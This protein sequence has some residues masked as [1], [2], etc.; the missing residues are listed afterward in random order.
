MRV[1][2]A[3]FLLVSICLPIWIL[4]SADV[5]SHSD[6][7]TMLDN[8]I[9]NVK[10]MLGNKAALRNNDLLHADLWRRLGLMLQTKDVRQHVGGGA[11]QPEALA[12]F[13]NALKFNDDL[14][15]E[16][17]FQVY[18]HRGML[19]KMM[20]RGDEAIRSHDMAYSLSSNP[21]EK[22]D[23]MSQKGA[24]QVMLGRVSEAINSYKRVLSIYPQHLST[25]LPLV[26]AHLELGNFTSSD[27]SVLLK[28]IEIAVGIQKGHSFGRDQMKHDH[29]SS[30]GQ[31][32]EE[33]SVYF[34]LFEVK[35]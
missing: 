24:A 32:T 9:D 21:N 5:L 22:A 23:A 35:I 18:Q 6:Q 10:N 12:A 33:S 2:A 16:L 14:D 13:D 34:A 17:S 28:D 3:M 19:L 11:L 30:H 25:Y 20:G 27:W 29:S 1:S 4:C 8:Q 15:L 31:S 7:M 26:Q